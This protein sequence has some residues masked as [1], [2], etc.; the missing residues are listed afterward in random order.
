MTEHQPDPGYG[1][2]FTISNVLS[3]LRI[4][5]LAP[6]LYYLG[7]GADQPE[8][9]LTALVLM[10][11]G[12]VT[13]MLDGWLARKLKQ[14][15]NFGRIIDPIADKIGIGLVFL[16]L[17]FTRPDFPV[18]FLI[19]VI[20]RDLLIFSVGMI[21]R[22]KY[23]FLFESNMIGKITVSVLFVYLTVFIL[24]DLYGLNTIAGI[25]LWTSFGFVVVSMVSYTHRLIAFF[26][27]LRKQN[28][29]QDVHLS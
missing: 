16:F 7:L 13:D 9:N 20:L 23:R 5:V 6:I 12:A 10:L 14:V 29:S 25:M 11:A 24:K 19:I 17:A 3:M 4:L 18:W 26:S 15:T 8:Y 27:G 2:I 1:R 28:Q 21:V 22:I